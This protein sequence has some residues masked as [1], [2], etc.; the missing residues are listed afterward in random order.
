MDVTQILQAIQRG[1]EQAAER[2]LPLVYDQLRTL[3]AAR[4]AREPAGNTLQ[5]TALVHEAWLRLG[6]DR[7]PDW[8]SRAQ[9]FAA[10]AEAMR[11]ILIDRA[12]KRLAQRRGGD[13]Q[14]VDLD[15]VELASAVDDDRV[16]QVNDALEKLAA[17]EPAKAELVKLRYFA[18]LTLEEAAASLQINER[19]ARRW[20]DFSRAWLLA[21]MAQNRG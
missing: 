7:Q 9:F 13:Q 14:R 11:R 21:E 5:A 20:W 2:L 16:L 19:T 4:M 6:A 1:E 12:R 3:A 17:L 18:G 15:D 8:Q 10:A